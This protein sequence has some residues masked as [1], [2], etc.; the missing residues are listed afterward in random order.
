[1]VVLTLAGDIDTDDNAASCTV[2]GSGPTATPKASTPVVTNT[3][4]Q[5]SVTP[6]LTATP[7]VTTVSP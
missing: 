1:M 4:S 3:P 2:Q 6:T 7:V 5:T